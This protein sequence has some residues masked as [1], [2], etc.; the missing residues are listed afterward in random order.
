LKSGDPDLIEDDDPDEEAELLRLI[1]RPRGHLPRN[2][3]IEYESVEEGGKEREEER[4]SSAL[5]V[6]RIADVF[7]LESDSGLEFAK[8]SIILT[9]IYRTVPV[10]VGGK[11]K[12]NL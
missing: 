1:D 10:P 4:T 6:D 12:G 5:S 7:P 11:K 9:D 3:F 8:G 2:P